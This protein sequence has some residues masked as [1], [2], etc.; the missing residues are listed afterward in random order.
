MRLAASLP[1]PRQARSSARSQKQL[2]CDQDRPQPIGAGEGTRTLDRLITN[3]LLCLSELRQHATGERVSI[4][5]PHISCQQAVR[6][7]GMRQSARHGWNGEFRRGG[8]GRWLRRRAEGVDS[9]Q[10][11][12]SGN[13]SVRGVGVLAA[14]PAPGGFGKPFGARP[15]ESLG[16]SPQ[17]ATCRITS[18]GLPPQPA[19]AN[20]PDSGLPSRTLAHAACAAAANPPARTTAPRPHRNDSPCRR[21]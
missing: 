10:G 16:D 5:P 14:V 1:L 4:H 8:V 17:P 18:S 21:H 7:R 6:T 9:D 13:Q 15:D 2:L 3:Q 12:A 20:R 11:F 19:R